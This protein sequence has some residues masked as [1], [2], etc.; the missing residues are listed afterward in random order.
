MA[1]EIEIVKYSELD[2]VDIFQDV[3]KDIT[4]KQLDSFDRLINDIKKRVEIE[5]K[6]LGL[7]E[8]AKLDARVKAKELVE[9]AKKECEKLEQ[10]ATK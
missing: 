5:R 8:E 9:E 6:K 3:V 7:G 4:E 1:K 10:Q 2:L